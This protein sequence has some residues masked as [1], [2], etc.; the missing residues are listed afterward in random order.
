MP[1]G[2]NLSWRE[3]RASRA[4]APGHASDDDRRLAYGT[5]LEQAEQLWQ[6]AATVSPVASPILLYYALVQGA[7]AWCAAA[8][9][10]EW[11]SERGGHGLQLRFPLDF[12][13]VPRLTDVNI[14]DNGRG[15][16]PHVAKALDSPTI[17]NDTSL[18]R[19]ICSLDVGGTFIGA[20]PDPTAQRVNVRGAGM[21]NFPG[22]SHPRGTIGIGVH[23]LILPRE[24]RDD[25]AS[26]EPPHQPV[27]DWLR[28]YPGFGPDHEP[29][30]IWVLGAP[31]DD[32]TVVWV[33]EADEDDVR[34]RLVPF[35]E[36]QPVEPQHAFLLTPLMPGNDRPQHPVVTWMEILY[37]MSMLAR[38]RPQQWSRMIDIDNSRDAARIRDVLDRARNDL[39]WLLLQ[40]MRR[41]R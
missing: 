4:D 8:I 6:S 19:L 10:G 18:S 1:L 5:A 7:Y 39:P 23:R 32:A 30:D 11:R 17:P 27:R 24:V 31:A 34:R 21:D 3:L 25:R 16:V 29:T 20:D 38:Y 36:L 2:P 13:P 26:A 37:G 33:S 35:E 41:L 22:A 9:E 15:F 12:E 40:Q 28:N 14:R